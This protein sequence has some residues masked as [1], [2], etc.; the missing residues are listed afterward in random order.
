MFGLLSGTFIEI[1]IKIRQKG[2]EGYG[3]KREIK[4]DNSKFDATRFTFGDS[5]ATGMDV[6]GM[7]VAG[8]ACPLARCTA[9]ESSRSLEVL[10]RS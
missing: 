2:V 4:H 9:L 10:E 6:S 5:D 3:T 8:F 1:L 7:V